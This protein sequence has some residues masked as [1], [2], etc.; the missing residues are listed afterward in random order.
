MQQNLGAECDGKSCLPADRSDHVPFFSLLLLPPLFLNSF[1]TLWM[2]N[3]Q[4]V[5]ETSIGLDK[6][7]EAKWTLV[8]ISLFAMALRLW[9]SFV[10]LFLDFPMDNQVSFV[11]LFGFFLSLSDIQRGQRLALENSQSLFKKILCLS[12]SFYS[13]FLPLFSLGLIS[14]PS[15]FPPFLFFISL[16]LFLLFV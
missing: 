9:L 8:L 12:L 10:F 4:F 3:A 2:P 11:W 7:R 1:A 6:L 16:L 14:L 15:F 5:N 13:T